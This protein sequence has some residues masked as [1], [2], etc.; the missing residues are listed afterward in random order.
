MKHIPPILLD[1]YHRSVTKQVDASRGTVITQE[2]VIKLSPKQKWMKFKAVQQISADQVA[3]CWRAKFKM[4]S[5]IPGSVVDEFKEGKGKLE[6]K[7][8]GVIPVA[9]ARGDKID[10]AEIQRYLA[11]IP[12]CP[13]AIV[14]N[15]SLCFAQK[16]D[17]C[18]RIWAFDEKN[19]VDLVF[20]SDGDICQAKTAARYQGEQPMPWE[21]HFSDY[22][23]F[24]GIRAPSTGKVQWNTADGPF[25]YWKGQLTSLQLT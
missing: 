25:I 1:F 10:Q 17:H 7:I 2:G 15:S 24:D 14:E 22:Q 5:L 13:A 9:R 8:L 23:N 21:G 4:A 6:A 16:S 19:Y 11:E 20:N 3:F 18:V 12:W